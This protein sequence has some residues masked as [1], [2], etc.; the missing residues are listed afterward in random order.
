M[1]SRVQNSGLA[2][3]TAAWH[4]YASR[5]LFAGWGTGSGAAA[6]A[7]DMTTPAAESRVSGTSSQQTTT[8]ANDTFR[9]VST[10]VATGSRAITEAALFDAAGTG[11]PPSGGNMCVYGDFS[12]INLA[13]DDSIAFT[14]D[15]AFS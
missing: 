4:A 10:I 6:S 2:N 7:N 13:A 15:V 14:F 11:N 1:V 9:V 8:V 3:I 5:P 12:V